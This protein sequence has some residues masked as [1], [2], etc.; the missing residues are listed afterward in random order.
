LHWLISSDVKIILF[1]ATIFA[2]VVTLTNLDLSIRSDLAWAL[3][4]ASI[5]FVIGVFFAVAV[6]TDDDREYRNSGQ[7]IRVVCGAMTGTLI[8]MIVTLPFEGIVSLALIGT[9]LGFFA[10]DWAQYV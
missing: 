5:F 6:I 3:R 2:I 8:G 7:T 10:K 9:V 4:V 1:F